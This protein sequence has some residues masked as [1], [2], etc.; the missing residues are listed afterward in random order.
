MT[1][2]LWFQ[3]GI[4]L[5]ITFVIIL[6]VMQV[7]IIF[8]PFITIIMTIFFPVLIGGLLYYITE[9]I[10]R[11]LEKREAHRL[12]SILAIFIIIL[13]VIAVITLTLLQMVSEQVQNL[14]SRVPI[15]QREVQNIRNNARRTDSL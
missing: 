7:Q 12:V 15:L 8:D 4:A 10:Q 11:F 3:S 2:K 1:N 13:I 14:V 9:P 5:I 6:L